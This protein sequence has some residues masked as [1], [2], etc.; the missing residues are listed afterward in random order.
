MTI[1][2]SNLVTRRTRYRA[3]EEGVEKKISGRILVPN[4]TVVTTSD[5]FLFVPVG[6]N[7][8]IKK[9]TLLVLG[10]SSTIAGSIG[11]FRILD[12]AGKAVVVERKG[13]NGE[14]STQYTS[15]ATS[16]ASLRS[17]GQLDGYTETVLATPA[18]LAGPTNVG[19]RITT[20]GTFGAETEMIVEVTLVGD[21]GTIDVESGYPD[22]TGPDLE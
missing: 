12:S 4:G 19:I 15:P 10:D 18:R 22:A 9:V 5:D 3:T 16:A 7:Q 13:P 20:G 6:E 11:T 8:V 2:N 1:Y 17:A 21:H 14:S